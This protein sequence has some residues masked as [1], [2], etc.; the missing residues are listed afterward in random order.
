MTAYCK[1]YYYDEPSDTEFMVGD[2][3]Q[4]IAADATDHG[5]LKCL[6]HGSKLQRVK[7]SRYPGVQ[8]RQGSSRSVRHRADSP[9]EER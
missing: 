3:L 4:G 5:V 9:H 7:G 6:V 2:I 1:I 8:H